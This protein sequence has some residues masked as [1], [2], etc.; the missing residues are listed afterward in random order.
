LKC[1]LTMQRRIPVPDYPRYP[2]ARQRAYRLLCELEIDRLPI[3]PWQ[4]ARSLPNVHVC[5]WTEL[6]DNC[7]DSDPL[8]IDAEGADAKTHHQRGSSDYLVVYDDRVDNY[9]RVRW[10]MAHELGH[11]VLGHLVSFDATALS[12]GSLTEKDY[13]VLEREADCFAA[14]ILAPM[15]IIN[16]IPSIKTRSDFMEVCDLS[17]MAADN[18]MEE[19][20]LL[21]SGKKLPFPIKEEDVLFR[22]FFRYVE[23]TNGTAVPSLKYDD[24]EIDEEYD[25]YIECDYW[26]FT[27]MTIRKWKLEKELHAALEGSMALYDCEDMVIFVKDAQ[28][29]AFAK[30]NEGIILDALQR[31]ADSCVRRIEVKVAELRR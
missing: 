25:D 21:K 6:R 17:G 2:F 29:A 7:H 11:I 30:Q 31:Y 26:N 19:L 13:K 24:L 8:F 16:R 27:V 23:N 22:L 5:K 28:S 18:C 15:T 14:N 3:D 9:Q 20:R 1:I 4:I 12:R 10:T